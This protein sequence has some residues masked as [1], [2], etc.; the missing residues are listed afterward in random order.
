MH[1]RNK[2]TYRVHT[3]VPPEFIYLLP[4]A[5]PFYLLQT[6]PELPVDDVPVRVLGQEV[7]QKL[8][9]Y[10]GQ[11][12]TPVCGDALLELRAREDACSFWVLVLTEGLE[13]PHQA[14]EL[15]VV[16]GVYCLP[17][18]ER[19]G[20]GWRAG[21]FIALC[22]Q[23]RP[24]ERTGKF[25]SVDYH[26]PSIV[27]RRFITNGHDFCLMSLSVVER[28]DTV[29]IVAYTAT[30]SCRCVRAIEFNEQGRRGGR[31]VVKRQ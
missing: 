23:C 25:R 3:M 20:G 28:N 11:P 12:P 29:G 30:G 10:L 27:L 14:V 16:Q 15:G 9:L 6:R 2:T 31:G 13:L 26:L 8:G 17:G 18:G 22:S 4:N 19:E 7:E 1:Q 24:A 5:P 21:G